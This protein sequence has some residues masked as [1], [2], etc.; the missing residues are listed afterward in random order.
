MA[1]KPAKGASVT[2]TPKPLPKLGI[3]PAGL[4]PDPTKKPPTRKVGRKSGDG[5]FATNKY[6]AEHPD[7]TETQDVRI[8]IQ[9]KPKQ[10]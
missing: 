4:G 3:K 6:V 5:T 8:G 9:K 10:G 1:K 7:T 2:P